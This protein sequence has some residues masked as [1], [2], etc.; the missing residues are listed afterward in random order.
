MVEYSVV[1]GLDVIPR[2]KV[3]GVY[4]LMDFGISVLI[5]L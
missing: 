1:R 3:G 2:W 4:Q 5:S